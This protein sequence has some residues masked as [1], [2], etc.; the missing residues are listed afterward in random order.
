MTAAG[1]PS[2]EAESR[3]TVPH[4]AIHVQRIE[5]DTAAAGVL[6]QPVFGRAF[7]F[8][9]EASRGPIF[10]DFF[11]LFPAIA[12]G[13]SCLPACLKAIQ[14]AHIIAPGG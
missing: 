14:F 11:A 2:L 3:Q 9:P 6:Y 13:Q 12:L 10:P 5:F 1:M 8:F 4:V 7:L